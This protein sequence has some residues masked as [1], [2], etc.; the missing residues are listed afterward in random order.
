MGRFLSVAPVTHEE[1]LAEL[2]PL[3]IIYLLQCQKML[4][5]V[6]WRLSAA[7]NVAAISCWYSSSKMRSRSRNDGS[8]PQNTTP[9]AAAVAYNAQRSRLVPDAPDAE[10]NANYP[11]KIANVSDGGFG[12]VCR[13]AEKSPDL[14]Q[15]DALMMLESG[16]GTRI[17]VQIQWVS[18]GRIG[19]KRFGSKSR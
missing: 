7:V 1:L 10:G 8:S 14:F 13:A 6:V 16:D 11:C 17:R 5:I 12:V 4:Q 9:G 3:N 19:L 18:H 15:T 2:A